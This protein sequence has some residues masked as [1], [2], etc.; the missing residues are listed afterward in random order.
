MAQI[1]VRETVQ[2][3]ANPPV[4]WRR[5]LN[6]PP[7]EWFRGEWL[8]ARIQR[9]AQEQEIEDENGFARKLLKFAA[10]IITGTVFIGGSLGLYFLALVTIGA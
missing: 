1:V 8:P 6:M 9:E 10:Y 3:T 5:E 7:Q 4:P 2:V